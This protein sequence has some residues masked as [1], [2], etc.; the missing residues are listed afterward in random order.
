MGAPLWGLG[1]Q[2]ASP[3]LSQEGSERIEVRV[4]EDCGL[5]EER[6]D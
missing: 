2:P 3:N 6:S 4:W 5:P 1:R